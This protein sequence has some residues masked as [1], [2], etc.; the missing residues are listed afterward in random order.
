VT[1]EPDHGGWNNI[2]MAMEVVLVFAYVTGRTLVMPPQQGMYLL[3]KGEKE[4]DN[5]LHFSDFFY[6]HRLKE[7]MKL[8]EMKDFLEQ[9]VGGSCSLSVSCNGCGSRICECRPSP[10]I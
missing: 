2:R 9:E 6:L 5:S 8:I 7:K 10:G 3:N 1:F 4:H